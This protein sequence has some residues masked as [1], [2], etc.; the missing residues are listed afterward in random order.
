[1]HAVSR[2]RLPSSARPGD[3]SYERDS[4]P[5]R[6]S[7]CE[8][9]WLWAQ[10]FRPRGREQGGRLLQPIEGASAHEQVLDSMLAGATSKGGEGRGRGDEVSPE[11]HIYRVRQ[12]GENEPLLTDPDIFRSDIRRPRP[13]HRA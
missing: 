9:R 5:Q 4:V 8:R 12:R 10:V 6:K 13:R 1:M 3:A 11:C 7:A 2:R